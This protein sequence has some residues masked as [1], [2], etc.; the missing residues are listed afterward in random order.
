M[1]QLNMC[2]IFT[3]YFLWAEA[4]NDGDEFNPSSLTAEIKSAHSIRLSWQ[5]A[6]N[7]DRSPQQ[8]VIACPATEGYMFATNKTSYILR[9]LRPGITY[10]CTIHS[11]S[12]SGNCYQ[13]GINIFATTLNSAPKTIKGKL[14]HANSG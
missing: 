13:P 7:S 2:F 3:I 8:Y 12:A 10:W 5:A 4:R 14:K 1:I 6:E 11:V 9:K